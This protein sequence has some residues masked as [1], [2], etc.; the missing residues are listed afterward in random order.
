MVDASDDDGLSEGEIRETTPEQENSVF[1]A[2]SVSSRQERLVFS[3][4]ENHKYPR[5]SSIAYNRDSTSIAHGNNKGSRHRYSDDEDYKRRHDGE[6]KHV[7]R[8]HAK[9]SRRNK[10]EIERDH[11]KRSKD[12]DLRERRSRDSHGSKK[13]DKIEPVREMEQTVLLISEQEPI[14]ELHVSP[15]D[16]EALIEQRRKNREAILAK[17]RGQHTPSL[18]SQTKVDISIVVSPETNGQL[19]SAC[20]PQQLVTD[21]SD[22]QLIKETSMIS[23]LQDGQ[24]AADYDPMIDGKLDEERQQCKNND[25]VN[26]ATYNEVK[27]IENNT[28]TLY[29]DRYDKVK[30]NEANV[31][32]ELDMFADDDMFADPKQ[33][34]QQIQKSKNV[35]ETQESIIFTARKLDAELLDNW[36]DPEGYY[37]VIIGELL[38]G[39]YAVRSNLGKGMFSGVVKAED[40]KTK[41]MVAIKLIRNNETMRKAGMRE[42]NFL[43]KLMEADPDD[44]KHIIRL[45]RHFEHKGHLCLVFETLSLNLRE[46]LKKFGND[47][48]INLKAVRAYAQQIFLG[49]SLLKKCNILHTDLKPDNI[50]VNE[51]R[52]YLKICDL[53]SATLNSDINITPYLVSRFYRAPEIILGLS[54]DYALDIWSIGCTLYELYTGKI[55]F[56][57]RTN[58]HMLRLM[59]ECRG[60]FNHKIIRRGQFS[61]IHFDE[62][63]N[64]ISIEKDKVTGNDVAKV[65]NITKPVRDLRSRLSNHLSNEDPKLMKNFIDLLERCLDLDPERRLSAHDA[66]KHPFIRG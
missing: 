3:H 38:D 65:T 21:T 60:K 32:D 2:D 26:A 10:V 35:N 45:E 58:N 39:R 28:L 43:K 57:G 15:V 44:R 24:T 59:M 30:I 5:K 7:S 40:S 20:S 14:E 37:H 27:Q 34:D 22:F 54:L 8:R 11:Q 1:L 62:H 51:T 4:S 13:K 49:L 55:L 46:I 18:S 66:L 33:T 17:Y 41:K 56:P 61:S 29:E 31:N 36:D 42:I 19:F 25:D 48:G 64:F 53:G 52:N 12:G 63:F 23:T 6:G 50:L 47:V 16:E 9:R